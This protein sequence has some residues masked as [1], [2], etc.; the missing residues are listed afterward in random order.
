M[1]EDNEKKLIDDIVAM[2]DQSTSEGV[3]HLNI[4]VDKNKED[5]AQFNRSVNTLSSTDCSGK[6]MAC[7]IPN[8]ME[9]LDDNK[10]EP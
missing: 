4:S 6:D 7:S 5:I 8:L 9:G 2:L 1:K 10:C 3:G